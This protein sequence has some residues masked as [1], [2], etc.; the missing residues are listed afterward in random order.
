MVTKKK[1]KPK[2]KVTK[3]KSKNGCVYRKV[4]HCRGNFMG[5]PDP[6]S[7]YDGYVSPTDN[8]VHIGNKCNYARQEGWFLYC[9]NPKAMKNSKE[10]KP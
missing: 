4:Y 1:D 9:E 7:F 10:Y 2:T 6:C 3:P 5:H 8:K